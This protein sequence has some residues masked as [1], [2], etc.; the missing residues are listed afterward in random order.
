MA[1]NQE[2]DYFIKGIGKGDDKIIR[3]FYQENFPKVAAFIL[4]NKGVLADAKD[5]FQDA[6]MLI[7]QQHQRIHIETSLNQYFYGIC[8]NIWYQR[9]RKQQKMTHQVTE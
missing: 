8:R 7:Y 9:L 6:V 5:V 4:N 1:S 2:K 3:A